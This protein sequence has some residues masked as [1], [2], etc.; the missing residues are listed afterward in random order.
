MLLNDVDRSH[1]AKSCEDAFLASG[2]NL[3]KVEKHG[4]VV[5][6]RIKTI[7]ETIQIRR[8][9]FEESATIAVRKDTSPETPP[10]EI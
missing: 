10:S 9:C 3:E 8:H 4:M 1:D 7:T 6:K 5:E 2:G